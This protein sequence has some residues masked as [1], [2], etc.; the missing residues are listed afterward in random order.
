MRRGRGRSTTATRRILDR[1]ETISSTVETVNVW[2]GGGND[3][4]NVDS[5]YGYGTTYVH[6]GAGDDTITV[7]TTPTGL[8]PNS[9][10]RVDFVAGTL[11]ING[12]DGSDTIVVDDS[13]DDN[14]N[15]GTYTG[16]AVTGLDMAGSIV[17]D[18]PDNITIQLGAQ[19]DTFYVPA[20]NAGL[21]TT[22][23]TGG[24]FDKVYIGTVAGQESE[25][26][27][28]GI[29]GVF[30]IDGEGPEAGTNCTSTTRATRSGRP[31]RSATSSS[32]W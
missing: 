6:G 29:Q 5:T 18:S 21:T 32:R 2:L 30:N 10:R 25:G 9:L 26:M 28:S 17:F 23:K 11:H 8:H 13:G 15:V 22:L 16:N 24:G 27:L 20:T 12:D 1:V 3:T 14:A 4:F 31:T 7:G 19:A